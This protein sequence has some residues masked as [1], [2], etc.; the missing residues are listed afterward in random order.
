MKILEKLSVLFVAGTIMISCTEQP[1]TSYTIEGN[2]QGIPEGAKVELIPGATHKDEK[3]VAETIVKDGKFTFTG[4]AD[5]PPRMF[6][7]HVAESRGLAK[8]M[9]E[10]GKIGLT[11]D[12]KKK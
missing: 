2:L 6:Y 7:I 11:G 12:V 10:N 8:L 1:A 4:V 3:P 9:V 5:E